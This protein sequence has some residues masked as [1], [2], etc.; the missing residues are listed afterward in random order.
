MIHCR[1][2]TPVK[3]HID[4]HRNE[5]RIFIILL[6]QPAYPIYAVAVSS[7]IS[8]FSY[9][10]SIFF[11]HFS[12]ISL[13][14][15]L[16]FTRMFHNGKKTTTKD[17]KKNV[18]SLYSL[19][20]FEN[21]CLVP[22]VRWSNYVLVCHVLIVKFMWWNS[23]NTLFAIEFCIELRRTN[24][25]LYFTLFVQSQFDWIPFTKMCVEQTTQ[26]SICIL[27][28]NKKILTR[29]S[30][31]FSFSAGSLG[32]WRELHINCFIWSK[33]SPIT[34][35]NRSVERRAALKRSIM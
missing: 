3:R 22:S 8:I 24:A 20:R 35:M 19:Q 12:S 10:F 13:S 2:K 33:N 9:F 4:K 28:I 30:M 15:P 16:L 34:M 1:C 21:V 11:F 26:L 14:L 27:Y 6:F 32:D 31:E 23:H 25:Y 5:C 18:V 7:F 29:K 17:E